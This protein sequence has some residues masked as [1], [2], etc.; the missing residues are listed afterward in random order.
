MRT[1]I[2]K[3][4]TTLLVLGIL[5]AT[6]M[7]VNVR[8]RADSDRESR[9]PSVHARFDLTDPEG[10]P[11]PSDRFTVADP[12]QNT[13]RRVNLPMPADCVANA[14]DCDDI[15]VLNRL[16]GFNQ[17]PRVSI[18]FD[19]EIDPATVNGNIFLLELPE[20]ASDTWAS[21]SCD[22]DTEAAE[23]DASIGR[24][25]GINQIVWDVATRTLHARS[26][27]A[28]REHARYALVVTSGVL[29]R[30]GNP[31]SASRDFKNYR[32]AL[33]AQGDAESLWYRRQLIRA[34]WA[35]RRAGV[36]NRDIAALSLFHTQSSTYLMRRQHEQ[37]FASAT[38][39]PADFRLGPG[40]SR[41][42][43]PLSNVASVTFNRQ[44]TTGATLSPTAGQLNL[45]R[46]DQGAI[47]LVAFGRYD[48]PDFR[49]HPG[50]YIPSVATG[51]GAP[52]PTGTETIY[53]NIYLPAGTQPPGGWPVAIHGLGSSSHKNFL[54]GTTTSQFAARGV[55]LIVINTAGH[56]HGPLSTLTV[57]RTNGTSVTFPAG[58]RS[59]DQNGDG[60]I[61]LDEGFR[62]AGSY[63][64]RDLYD[65][66]AQTAADL[67]QL[68]RVIRAGV[69]VDGDGDADL[70]AS[71][72]TY[73]GWSIGSNYG[74]A[75]FA[76]T[77]EI[78]SAAFESI[79]GPA[80][81][82]RRLSTVARGQI[83]TELAARTPSLLNSVYG[84]TE[85]DGGAV[86]GPYFN[87]NQ[88]LRDQPPVVNTVP[89]AIP[90]QQW[91]E[92][93]AWAGR[94][95]DA[96]AYAPLV[97]L[98]PPPGVAPRPLLIHFARNEQ[99][100]QNP[101]TSEIV[102]AGGLADRAVLFRHDLFYPTL[103]Q[104]FRSQAFVKQAHWWFSALGQAPL[105]PIVLDAQGQS[106]QF[107]LSGGTVLAPMTNMLYWEVPAVT[108]PETLDYIP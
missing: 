41:T 48:A 52:A 43:F 1:I 16:D 103:D 5:T 7:V 95:A 78:T 76:S 49:A 108:L 17:H 25:V 75:L 11:F 72:I 45:L 9:A 22:G 84:L 99:R 42:V 2:L 70:D 35:A 67:M 26:D 65:G 61:D 92:R 31:I 97:R 107:L 66:Y 98:R 44:M 77:P 20:S 60:A 37:V 8:V 87:E 106:A 32:R 4:A 93:R 96:A 12:E 21:P 10:G 51:T 63:S 64:I 28:L 62:A 33:R 89:G 6:L 34:E 69:D 38:P 101:G 30:N 81:E 57:A 47:S 80:T 50:E 91:L 13:R 68:V 85:I 102:R 86:P 3:R 19:G 74:M 79:G 23:D 15:R 46:F 58:G 39:P 14:S 55:A 82:H 56:G 27:E 29:D 105:R 104:T 40:G 54:S 18:P 90:I 36:R 59:V 88:P 94:N 24:V 73:W 100:H 53:F 71:R 83:G